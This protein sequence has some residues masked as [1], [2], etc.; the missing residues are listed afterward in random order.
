MLTNRRA[1]ERFAGFIEF[2]KFADLREAP[3]RITGTQVQGLRLSPLNPHV[4]GY[5]QSD[6]F[7]VFGSTEKSQ[8]F[9]DYA[10]QQIFEG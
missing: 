5:T 2:T 6:T 9:T 1:Y 4:K 3:V 8:T 10:T 7:F